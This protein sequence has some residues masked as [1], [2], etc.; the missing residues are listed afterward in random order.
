MEAEVSSEEAD[1]GNLVS[2]TKFLDRR[3]R[4]PSAAQVLDQRPH[5]GGDRKT[6]LSDSAR[7]PQDRQ[8]VAAVAD[9]DTGSNPTVLAGAEGPASRFPS[10]T[11][12][13]RA[14]RAY[15]ATNGNYAAMADMLHVHN[16]TVRYRMSRVS[17]EFSL[18]LDDPQQRLW[19]W[20]RMAT[21][22]LERP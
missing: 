19:L 7:M 16:N 1:S 8:I 5:P 20:L 12:R 11:M 3:Q 17:K 18:N 21:T 10:Q 22:D 9:S 14:V 6:R 15:L 4:P 13:S 2:F